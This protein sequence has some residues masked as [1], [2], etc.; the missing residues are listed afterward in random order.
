MATN[1]GF[2]IRVCAYGKMWY[3]PMPKFKSMSE[4]GQGKGRCPTRFSLRDSHREDDEVVFFRVR[5]L[6]LKMVHVSSVRRRFH[7]EPVA[8][9][10]FTLSPSPVSRIAKEKKIAGL[11]SFSQESD[12]HWNHFLNLLATNREPPRGQTNRTSPW[13]PRHPTRCPTGRG[14]F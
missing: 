2:Y 3:L 5:G 8:A 11:E 12:E 6:A 1:I 9:T 7:M 14:S 4:D 10:T 13:P